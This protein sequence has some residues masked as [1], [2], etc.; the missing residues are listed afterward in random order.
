ME[1]IVQTLNS[2]VEALEAA[3]QSQIQQFHVQ[4]SRIDSL[5]ALRDLTVGMDDLEQRLLQVEMIPSDYDRRMA[6][7]EDMV[8][9]LLA[10]DGGKS[11]VDTKLL[12]KPTFVSWKTR[13]LAR[14]ELCLQCL[15]CSCERSHVNSHGGSRQSPDTRADAD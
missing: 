8:K 12:S 9:R 7:L 14:L 1:Q 10:Q 6:L 5:E 15:L 2:R 13:R 4:S 11:A 3:V